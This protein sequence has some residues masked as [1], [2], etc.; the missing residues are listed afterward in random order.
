MKGSLVIILFLL[1]GAL[2]GYVE[3][4]PQ[5]IVDQGWS[6]YALGALMFGVGLS[7]GHNPILL[8]SFRQI[9]PILFFLPLATIMGTLCASAFVS[10]FLPH[11]SMAQ[12]LAIG[13][14][15]GYYS[16][17]SIFITEYRGAEA[18]TIALLSNIIREVIALLVAPVLVRFS[19]AW[20]PLQQQEPPPWTP[21]CLSLFVARDPIIP[22]FLY[23]MVLLWI[24][25]S[26]SLS[27]FSVLLSS[28]GRRTQVKSLALNSCRHD[29]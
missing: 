9:R 25:A 29:L 23:I 3:V 15:F 7:I 28:F 13:S 2:C 21:R 5:E 17:S 11:S 24:S 12:S 1:G 8:R 10:L 14:G 27:P 22:S 20:P 18:G 6:A 4:F 16:L 19:G 26:L